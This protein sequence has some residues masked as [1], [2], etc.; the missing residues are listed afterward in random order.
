MKV[1]IMQPYFVP[2]IG[3]WQLINA[4]DKYVVYDDVNFIKGGWIN[5]NR[6]LLN[7][8]PQY[9]NIPMLGASPHKLINEIKVNHEKKLISK[10][11]KMIEGAYKKAPYY[12]DIFPLCEKILK[13]EK[14]NIALFIVDS[15]EV[16]C[17]YLDIKTDFVIS[18]SLKKDNAQKG[19]DKVL[20]IC[21]LLGAT[22][23]W[24]AIGGQKLYSF[25]DFKEK[26]VQLKF[27]KPLPLE[28]KQFTYEYQDNLS[29]LD[30][31]MFNS[32][33]RVKGFLNQYTIIAD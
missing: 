23:Y 11:L 7:G 30:V 28:Y 2:Y 4:V 10:N 24:N 3:Y 15:F 26:K 13:S 5:R 29:I 25:S 20:T 33:E 32:K 19:Q 1:G 17:D 18:S 8:Q 16:I 12:S 22:E 27:L 9:I 6:I 21:T 14:E 31:L